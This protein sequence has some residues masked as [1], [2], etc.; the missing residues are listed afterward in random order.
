[1]PEAARTSD[2][3]FTPR[4]RLFTERVQVDMGSYY[5]PDFQEVEAP[6]IQLTF[7]YGAGGGASRTEADAEAEARARFVLESLGALELACAEHVEAPPGS[8]ADYLVR[9]DGDVHARCGFAA[10][11]VPQLRDLG[12][13]VEVDPGYRWQVLDQGVVPWYA[14]LEPDE[15][16]DWF[17]L[18]LGVEHDGQRINLLPTLLDLLRSGPRSLA[19]LLRKRRCVAIP[20]GERG[21]LAL[22]P[23]RLRLLAE[24]LL[25]LY[26][27]A[28]LHEDRLRVPAACVG[29]LARLERAL[30]EPGRR[31]GR[32]RLRWRGATD[33]LARAQAAAATPAPV[34][35]PEGLRAELRP[36]QREGVAWL[37]HLTKNG[38]GGILADDMGL[39]KTPQTIAHLLLEH[40]AGGT[41]DPSLVVV[42]TSLVGNWRRELRRFAPGLWVT[43][44]HGARRRRSLRLLPGSDVVIT[45]YPVLTRDRELLAAQPFHLV[46]LDEAQAIKNN[47]SQT[48]RAVCALEARHRLCLTGTPME[49]NLGEIWSLFDFVMPGFLGDRQQFGE[50][51]AQPIETGGDEPS[52]RALRRRVAPFILR[53]EKERVARELPAKTE[54]VRPVEISGRQRELYE[55]I[56]IAAHA[57]VRHAIAERGMARSTVAI[58]DALM[59]LRQVCCD[60]RLVRM[61]AARAVT[62]SAKLELLFDLLPRQLEQGRRVLLFSQFTS[63]LALI[64]EELRRRGIRHVTLTG[65]TR[66]R[67]AR[68]D[69]FQ[70]GFADLFLISLKAGGT[71]LNLTR[72]DT[73]I[74]YDP[75]W[76]P[77]AQAQATDRAHRIGQTRP[78][79][80]Y[81][82]IVAGSVEERM[83]QLQ[84]RKRTLAQSLLGGSGSFRDL[85]QTEVDSLFSPLGT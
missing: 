35:P 80:V 8:A 70:H 34:R 3:P 27:E 78:V 36:Y 53:R 13:Q 51:F 1:M 23:E 50:R 10:Y 76:N 49:N 55:S 62:G 65:A 39:G 54:I 68:L 83:L 4:V 69:E 6:A 31:R 46:I 21:F 66:D 17:S 9:L 15:E 48:H 29:A 12:W 18:E 16:A 75:W 38:V 56:R 72:A 82:L 41:R 33:A 37:Q 63:M 64:G 60:P 67:Q 7:D 19:G 44:Y 81:N 32:R 5:A 84:R 58:L 28:R 43:V 74:H 59:K 57:Q 47:R 61:N 22:P 79:F 11:A 42:P 85:T 40:N 14:S 77:A 73:V 2:P 52:L 24:V 25:E 71:G 20:V 45:T 26:G 30:E